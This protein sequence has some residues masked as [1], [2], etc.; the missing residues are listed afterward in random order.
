MHEREIHYLGYFVPSVPTMTLF[1]KE[2]EEL[3]L[4]PYSEINCTL[5]ETF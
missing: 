3:H 5:Y 2:G 4:P 1:L